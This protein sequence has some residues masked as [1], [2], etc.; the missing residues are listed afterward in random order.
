MYRP[1]FVYSA[2]PPQF[3]DT[4]FDHYFDYNTVPALNTTTFASGGI[5]V[6]VPLVLMSDAPFFIR[7]IQVKAVNAGDPVVQTQFKDP[8]GNLLSDD[9]VA[10]DLTFA[11]D[12]T[13]IYFC[14]IVFEPELPC[15]PGSSVRMSVKNQ[16]SGTANLQNVRVLLSGVKRKW[17]KGAKCA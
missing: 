2:T 15:P 8:Y 9:F 10:L 12:G 13:A 6:D 5:L 14:N 4:D 11:P 1:Q 7:G 17:A 16:T 3:E